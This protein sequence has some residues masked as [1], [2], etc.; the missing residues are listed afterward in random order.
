MKTSVLLVAVSLI[1]AFTIAACSDDDP[2]GPSG[3]SAIP[4]G[5]ATTVFVANSH[6]FSI[7]APNLGATNLAL[8]L[9]GDL[10][11]ETEFV[12]APTDLQ[13]GLGPVFNSN[14]CISCH[15][16]DGRG[17]PPFAGERAQQ[18]LLRVSVPGI[19]ADGGPNPADGF[20]R[21]FFDKSIFGVEPYGEFLVDWIEES[22]MFEDGAAY[23]LRRPEIRI[24]S[25]YRPLPGNLLISPRVP[26]GVFGTGLLEAL[27]ESTIRSFADPNDRDG[28]GIS[29]R[30]NEVRNDRTG[31]IEIGRFGWKANT[32]TLEQ[33]TAAAYL[34]DMGITSPYYPI[35]SSAGTGRDDG[36]E[37]D[38][39]I[40]SDILLSA[41]R[42]VQTLGVPARRNVDDPEVQ[43][44]EILF[45][46]IG[47]AGCHRPEMTTGVLDD[48]P[49]VSNQKI[50]PYTDLLLHDM[51]PGLADNR[52]D[53]LASGQEWRTPPLWGIGLT[54]L[55]NGHTFFL[56]DG[57]A[58]SISEAI[59]W[60][61]G[62]A[63]ATQE[64]YRML[65]ASERDDLIAFVRSL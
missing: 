45:S 8:H 9:D 52:P 59:L 25:S 4:A 22:G 13:G 12:A 37:D 14:S 6:A 2:G 10:Q 47:C 18:M 3:S 33:Q 27:S 64:R 50:A 48:V 20:G 17:R 5:G 7:P 43:R 11:F 53:F 29:G 63:A 42:Y 36:V 32:P 40:D 65:S 28:N 15:V 35:E 21:Q 1:S 49:E 16:R 46:S 39:E 56:H 31:Q 60:H 44:G 30:V 38:P 51:G 62:E 61:G 58:R 34:N 57:R 23:S 19:G 54:Y 41:T 55:V 24:T 26:P